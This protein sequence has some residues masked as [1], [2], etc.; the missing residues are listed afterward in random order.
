M[1]E[2]H[3]LIPAAPVSLNESHIETLTG[4]RIP[5]PSTLNFMQ[6][7]KDWMQRYDFDR[8]KP[9]F[10]SYSIS[11]LLLFDADLF[12]TERAPKAS[13]RLHPD[14]VFQRRDTS[15]HIKVLEDA[16]FDYLGVPDERVVTFRA[17][18]RPALRLP[19]RPLQYT[20]H[21]QTLPAGNILI[22]VREGR[23]DMS[24]QDTE[25]AEFQPMLRG[26]DFHPYTG[27]VQPNEETRPVPSWVK[28]CTFPDAAQQPDL[29]AECALYTNTKNSAERADLRAHMRA[30]RLDWFRDL[31]QVTPEEAIELYVRRRTAL[32]R[33]WKK[34]EAGAESLDDFF[35]SRQWVAELLDR[36]T[37]EHVIQRHARL[38]QILS[39]KPIRQSVFDAN[40]GVGTYLSCLRPHNVTT[41]GDLSLSHTIAERRGASWSNIEPGRRF[42]VV[43]CLD[44]LDLAEDPIAL[45]TYLPRH[46]VPG[47]RLVLSYTFKSKVGGEKLPWIRTGSIANMTRR[48]AV[49]KY[50]LKSKKRGGL[51]FSLADDSSLRDDLKVFVYTG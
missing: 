12:F 16:I 46:L 30:R 37:L 35:A 2:Y 26:S 41:A 47:G 25:V 17:S 38:A 43:L 7:V 3:Y 39:E 24:E 51:G 9:V 11:Y 15:N 45:L 49:Q 40:T 19:T 23:Y 32:R 48:E 29:V 21:E 13:R 14:A 28:L 44:Y 50:I 5:K 27:W 33:H 10:Q 8:G 36:E 20:P 6:F 22:I 31:L 4:K 18:K 34:V 1:R 42:S